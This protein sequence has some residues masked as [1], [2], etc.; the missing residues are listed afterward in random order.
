VAADAGGGGT[1][2][3]GSSVAVESLLTVLL[4]HPGDDR[5][6]PVVH[7]GVELADVRRLH[8]DDLFE[9]GQRA[10]R[11]ERHGSRHHLEEGDAERVDVGAVIGTLVEALLRRQVAG[12]AHE[13]AGGGEPGGGRAHEGQTEVGDLDQAAVSDHEV[14]WFDVAVDHPLGVGVLEACRRLQDESGGVCRLEPPPG[15]D[16]P[17]DAGA[18]DVLHDEVVVAVLLGDGV[19]L[20]DVRVG[21]GGGAPRLAHETLDVLVVG[22][23]V[24]AENLDGDEAVERLFVG[25]VDHAHAAAAELGN[26][27]VVTDSIHAASLIDDGQCYPGCATDGKSPGSGARYLEVFRWIYH[28]VTGIPEFR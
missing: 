26:D 6:Q 13:H 10:V 20:D 4:D 3:A 7:S 27:G 11:L 5:T 25:L 19:D 16:H 12:G 15:L 2:G 18:L 9:Q 1:A 23:E 22:L 14:G 8:L 21:Q 17:L 28:F 24:L